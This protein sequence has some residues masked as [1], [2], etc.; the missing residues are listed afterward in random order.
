MI[1]PTQH[2]FGAT[3]E[4][5]GNAARAI[6]NMSPTSE[7]PHGTGIGSRR[8]NSFFRSEPAGPE[9]VLAASC[10]SVTIVEGCYGPRDKGKLRDSESSHSTSRELVYSFRRSNFAGLW[11]PFPWSSIPLASPGAVPSDA[12]PA[13]DAAVPQPLRLEQKT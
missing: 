7:G 2:K 10:P 6:A 3:S 4:L 9:S 1:C 8:G 5:V 12:V 11:F 13:L